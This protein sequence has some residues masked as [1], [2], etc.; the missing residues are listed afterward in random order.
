MPTVHREH[1]LSFLVYTD[2]HPPPHV[3]VAGRGKARIAL[4]PEVTLIDA[5]GLTNAD[6]RRAVD[7]VKVRRAQMLEIWNQFHE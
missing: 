7:V 3:H 1:G 5:R 4:E 2:D 6:I